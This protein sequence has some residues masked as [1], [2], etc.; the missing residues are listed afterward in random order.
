MLD[1]YV[2]RPQAA[3][4]L[5]LHYFYIPL[6]NERDEQLSSRL[7]RLLVTSVALT[8]RWKVTQSHHSLEL[9]IMMAFSVIEGQSLEAE[10]VAKGGNSLLN[11]DL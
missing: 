3:A 10:C 11:L 4:L 9:R 7:S 2:H 8:S 6:L 5:W 1:S